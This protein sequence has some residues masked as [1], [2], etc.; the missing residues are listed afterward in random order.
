[1]IPLPPFGVFPKMHPFWPPYIHTYVCIML[2]MIDC[3]KK[4]HGN[5]GDDEDDKQR[6]D[7]GYP[8]Q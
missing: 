5:H 1:M 4:D 2:M 6:D 8:E 3:D 7:D